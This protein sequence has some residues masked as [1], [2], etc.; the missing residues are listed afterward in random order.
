MNYAVWV[1]VIGLPDRVNAGLRA[2]TAVCEP[3][4]D[5]EG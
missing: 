5:A 3:L 2:G 4:P 1:V